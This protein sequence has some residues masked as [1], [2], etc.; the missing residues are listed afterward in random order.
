MI[1]TTALQSTHP[2]GTNMECLCEH[3]SLL[4]ITVINMLFKY[5]FLLAAVQLEKLAFM[6]GEGK[7]NE[8][9]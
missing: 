4:G 3:V 9:V 5:K 7:K 1:Q 8:I 6:F 2:C